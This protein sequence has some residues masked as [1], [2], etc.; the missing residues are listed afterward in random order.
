MRIIGVLAILLFCTDLFSQ[1]GDD[2]TSDLHKV[3]SKMMKSTFKIQ[4][5]NSVGTAF[6][7]L[8]RLP[9]KTNGTPVLIAA[10][11]YRCC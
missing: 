1:E 11:T 10:P 3:D 9:D 4:V 5:G 8:D 6:V 7:L 2:S